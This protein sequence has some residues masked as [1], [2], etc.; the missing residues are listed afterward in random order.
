L[1]GKDCDNK[2]VVNGR[3]SAFAELIDAATFPGLQGTPSFNH[4]AA[5]AVFFSETETEQYR[6]RQF[7]I[8]ENAVALAESLVKFG[9]D[10]VTGGTDNHLILVDVTGLKNGSTGSPQVGLT[11]DIAQKA[12]EECGIVVDKIDLPYQKA[13]QAAGI[14][15]GTPI[16]TKNGMTAQQMDTIAG[17]IDGIL[18]QVKAASQGGCI[19]DDVFKKQMLRR[20]EQLCGQFVPDNG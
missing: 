12:L 2:I 19:I 3:K 1:M 17:M 11:G 8:I 18:R 13:G 14:R 4:I 10:I 15:L 9:L 6:Q 16:V 5:K 20:V 7:K